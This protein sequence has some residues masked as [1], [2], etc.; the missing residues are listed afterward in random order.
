MG[1][2]GRTEVRQGQ[3]WKARGEEA[4]GVKGRGAQ[5]SGSTLRAWAW[6]EKV[7]G[8]LQLPV[9]TRRGWGWREAAP[10]AGG[11]G[12]LANQVEGRATGRFAGLRRGGQ[13]QGGGWWRWL[14]TTRD[15]R[16]AG[17]GGGGEGWGLDFGLPGGLMPRGEPFPKEKLTL[18]PSRIHVS[19]KQD[20]GDQPRGK[21]DR[22]N[23][24]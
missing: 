8:Y 5:Q 6:L 7:V 15:T 1:L 22:V 2:P 10:P 3:A 16:R 9:R 18:P 19:G 23:E 20:K 12:T 24:H 13:G 21:G 11:S 14:E 17:R 4:A